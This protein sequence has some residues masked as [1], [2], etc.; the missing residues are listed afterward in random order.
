MNLT[1]KEI[2]YIEFVLQNASQFTITRAQDVIAPGVK[3]SDVKQKIKDYYN[4]LHS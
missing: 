2:K 3:H 4:R 1:S